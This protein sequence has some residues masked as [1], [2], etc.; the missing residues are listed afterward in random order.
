MIG[1]SQVVNHSFKVEDQHNFVRFEQ[2]GLTPGTHTL[3]ATASTG[4]SFA[5][6]V[7]IRDGEPQWADL[8]Y[9][10]DSDEGQHQF[11]F[12]LSHEPIHFI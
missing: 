4:Q 8:T 11:S 9:A 10:Y 6:T 3:E 7:T 1:G 5:T 2:P 12:S